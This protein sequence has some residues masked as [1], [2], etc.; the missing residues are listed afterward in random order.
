MFDIG[1]TNWQIDP[2]SKEV[3]DINLSTVMIDKEAILDNRILFNE[4]ISCGEDIV[5]IMDV[6]KLGYPIG[7]RKP[8]V[9]V[10]E[11]NNKNKNQKIC[12]AIVH[13][14]KEYELKIDEETIKDLVDSINGNKETKKSKEQRLLDIS[15][16]KYYLTK[17]YKY[18]NKVR[19]I[20][21]RILHGENYVTYNKQLETISS[22][23]LVSLYRVVRRIIR[24]IKR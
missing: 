2:L 9:E 10:I 20:K 23:K 24:K 14:L 15:R 3:F 13:L 17:E 5:F 11:I 18:V 1:F 7:I 16:Y 12:N 22:G 21:N 6:L 8:L 19:N 4:D